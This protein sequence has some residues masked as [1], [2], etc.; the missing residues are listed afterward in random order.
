MNAMPPGECGG[1]AAGEGLSTSSR[2]QDRDVVSASALHSSFAELYDSEYAFVVRFLMRCGASLTAAQVAAQDA[3]ISAWALVAQDKWAGAVNWRAWLRRV[4]LDKY[5]S[6]SPRAGPGI[7]PLPDLPES[8]PLHDT[9]TLTALRVLEALRNLP[10]D[11][12]VVIAFDMDGFP[13]SITA[14]YLG[15]TEKE[16]RNL[17]KEAR[18]ILA[19]KLAGITPVKRRRNP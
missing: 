17:L 10:P 8:A 19:H 2:Q 5:H 7:V 18:E 9:L 14:L 4:A 13:A 1:P 6:P 15:V 11:M 3:F 16:V 12:Q